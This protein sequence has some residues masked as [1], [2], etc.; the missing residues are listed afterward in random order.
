MTLFCV[1]IFNKFGDN[2]FYKQWK[3]P[4]AVPEGEASL[5]AGFVYTLQRISSQMSTTGTGG[6]RAVQ[7]P[8]YKL[9]YFETITGYRLALLTDRD[10]P[11]DSTQQLLEEIFRGPFN[12]CVTRSPTYTHTKG[13]LITGTEFD[14]ALD[15]LLKSKKLI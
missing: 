14:D 4:R 10:T 8:F 13:C 5:V 9:H 12:S 7:T 6:F 3:R 2:I 11:T 1:Y 15:A